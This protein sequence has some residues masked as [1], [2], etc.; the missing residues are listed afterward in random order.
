MPYIKPIKESYK[1]QK[2][3]Y[4]KQM[5]IQQKEVSYT[6]EDSK[7]KAKFYNSNAW[8]H[9]RSKKISEQ[10]LCELCLQ[11]GMT[12]PGQEVH[13]AIK[14]FDQYNEADKW[15]LLLDPDNLVT[16]CK[17]CHQHI[18]KQRDKF[19]WPEQ[20][21][22]LYDKKTFVTQKFFDKGIIIKWTNDENLP[23]RRK[24]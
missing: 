7:D 10:P 11:R 16:V 1:E 24:N 18:H 15:L 21:K 3:T 23:S 12:K 19:L 5:N 20:R 9:L 22:Y 2:Q 8:K 13:H 17:S 4:L 14:F 6:N